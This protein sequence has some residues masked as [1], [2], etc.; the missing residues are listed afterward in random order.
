MANNE[1]HVAVALPSYGLPSVPCHL[2][3]RGP[4][5][6]IAEEVTRYLTPF[7]LKDLGLAGPHRSLF[8]RCRCMTLEIYKEIG[9]LIPFYNARAC[10]CLG[11]CKPKDDKEVCFFP[12]TQ[13]VRRR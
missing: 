1:V 4:G 13:P 6:E 11:C 12:L 7:M 5:A 2:Q 9:R 8:E 10:E 3:K